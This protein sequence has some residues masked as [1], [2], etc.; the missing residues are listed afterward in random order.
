MVLGD[1]LAKAE[2]P[3]L[4]CA[5]AQRNQAGGQIA[6]GR[7]EKTVFI[8]YRR[9]D[10]PWGLAI[11]QNLTQHGYDVFIDYDGIAGGNFESVI[12]ENIRARAHFLVLLTPTALERCGNPDD[13]MRREIE[14]ALDSKRNIVPLMLVGFDF[15]TPATA[16]QLTGKLAALKNYNGLE[17]PNVRFFSSEMERLRNK[18]LNV[19]VD[20]VLHPAS[21]SAQQV[22][23]EQ[24]DKAVGALYDEPARPVQQ[25]GRT[26]P[27][28]DR[29]QGIV[30]VSYPVDIDPSKMKQMVS[31]L[32]NHGFRI[33]LYDP[34]PF[35]FSE[36]E[37]E[38]IDYQKGGE[39]YLKQPRDAAR[40]AAV[41]LFLIS[42]WTLGSR[43][44]KAELSIALKHGRLV[45]YIVSENVTIEDLPLELSKLHVMSVAE[46]SLPEQKLRMLVRTVASA[47]ARKGRLSLGRRRLSP[48]WL[49]AGGAGVAVALALVPLIPRLQPTVAIQPPESGS[50][51]A[52]IPQRPPSAPLEKFSVYAHYRP[53]NPTSKAFA[54]TA[55][56][57]L[58]EQGFDVQSDTADSTVQSTDGGLGRQ[59]PY[60]RYFV[61]KN[62]SP[63]ERERAHAAAQ[64]A[65][66]ALNNS[67]PA[68]L[69]PFR[70]PPPDE[71]NYAAKQ[72]RMLAVW[73]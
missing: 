13:W 7:I 19:E 16:S 31:A 44:Q 2:I 40:D 47:S 30:F 17:I 9:V 73:F 61:D 28:A 64:R 55:R 49:I 66:D 69:G 34:T 48:G 68:E 8:S 54:E 26:A 32:I 38:R 65:A 21:D 4:N 27:Q 60:I 1:P 29:G 25:V 70:V 6:M 10:G 14:T 50:D 57:V 46:Q 23:K 15:G 62:A 71:G 56:K 39:D 67:R 20:A 33:W 12:L 53:S 58:S 18:Y 24:R 72:S 42:R 45:P 51:S 63:E 22:A 35:G 41:V 36:N 3:L 59:G 5:R 37:L 52:S 11:F 43:F